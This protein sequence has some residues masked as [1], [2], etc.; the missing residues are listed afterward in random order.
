[1]LARLL[2]QTRH[3]ILKGLFLIL[4]ALTRHPTAAALIPIS[5]LLL[6]DRLDSKVNRQT[7][8]SGDGSPADPQ[9]APRRSASVRPERARKGPIQVRPPGVDFELL[10]GVALSNKWWPQRDSIPFVLWNSAGLYG[11]A[12]PKETRIVGTLTM[13]VA[14][15]HGA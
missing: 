4:L 9:E 15:V 8:P 12:S 7:Q 3:P 14:L 13:M 1:M 5:L 10:A 2:A 11:L 6:F